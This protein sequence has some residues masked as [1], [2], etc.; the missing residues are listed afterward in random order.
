MTCDLKKKK[1][2]FV[3]DVVPPFLEAPSEQRLYVSLIEEWGAKRERK[4]M[5]GKHVWACFIL[6][7]FKECPHIV[8]LMCNVCTRVGGV[9]CE[10][11]SSSSLEK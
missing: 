2:N 8:Y 6:K 5:W 9:C 3:C 4:E 7:V 11:S 1:K 10:N